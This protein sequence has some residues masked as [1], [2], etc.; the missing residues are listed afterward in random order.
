MK[1]V[2]QYSLEIMGFVDSLPRCY[3][4]IQIIAKQLIRS[5]TSIGANVVEAQ[6]GSSKNDF[7]NFLSYALKSANETGYWLNL[8]KDSGKIKDINKTEAL[9][10]EAEELAKILGSSVSSLKRNK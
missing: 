3:L 6:A 4:S 5:A 1:R 2:Y 10:K 7:I 8:L 9:V